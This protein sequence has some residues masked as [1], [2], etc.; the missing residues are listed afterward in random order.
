M[1]NRMFLA[2]IGTT[3]ALTFAISSLHAVAAD[4]QSSTKATGAAQASNQ[5]GFVGVRLKGA[6]ITKVIKDTPASVASLA[7]GDLVESIDKLPT[8]TMK[9]EEASQR[10]RGPLN[11]K[12]SIVIKRNGQRF[13]CVLK[14]SLTADAQDKLE[15][16]SMFSTPTGQ[17]PPGPGGVRQ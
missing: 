5:I 9:G 3:L 15:H 16:P 14:R 4:A 10:I 8:A 6:T 17:G 11:T 13:A 1:L 12:V 7:P 2:I